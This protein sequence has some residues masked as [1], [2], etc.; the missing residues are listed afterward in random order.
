MERKY[1]LVTPG[2]KSDQAIKEWQQKYRDACAAGRALGR[3]FGAGE[4]YKQ[5]N[6]ITAFLFESDPGRSWRKLKGTDNQYMPHLTT[7]EG[8]AIGRRIDG[9]VIPGGLEFAKIIGSGFIIREQFWGIPSFQKIGDDYVLSIP[10]GDDARFVPP[11][12]KLLKMSEY[13][14]LKE[15]AGGAE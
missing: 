1:Y 8:K 7:K 9:I 4:V 10:D 2:G 5:R 6:R 13:Y 12:A 14:A 15:A 3:E 11:D